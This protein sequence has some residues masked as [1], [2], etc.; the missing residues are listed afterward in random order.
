MA[1]IRFFLEKPALVAALAAFIMIAGITA[2]LQIPIQLTPDV[3]TPQL[4]VRTIWPGASP[5]EV[6]KEIVIK[7]E[8]A[9][10]N[11]PGLERLTPGPVFTRPRFVDGQ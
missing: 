8:D 11:L 4:T 9:L 6:E 5:Y 3:Q 7:Q 2:L 10:R 1:F